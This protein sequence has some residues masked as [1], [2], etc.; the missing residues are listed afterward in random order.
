MTGRHLSL[1]TSCVLVVTALAGCGTNPTP[2]G[3]SASSSASVP[4]ATATPLSPTSVNSTPLTSTTPLGNSPAALRSQAKSVTTRF[5]QS[6]FT[7]GYPDD[8]DLDTYLR[9]IQP[10]LSPSGYAQQVSLY[11]SDPSIATTI[12]GYYDQRQRVAIKITSGPEVV[13]AGSAAATTTV[14]YHSLV[15]QQVDGDWKTSSTGTEKTETVSLATTNND[16]IYLVDHI[17]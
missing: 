13:E 9:R 6:A 15:Q 2:S 5:M 7:V 17:A 10:M 11:R 3:A 1:A 12:K 4:S 8:R 16:G 14:K